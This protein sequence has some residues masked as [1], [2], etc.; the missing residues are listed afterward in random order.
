[1]GGVTYVSDVNGNLTNCG[2]DTLTYDQANRLT[3]AVVGSTIASYAYDGDGK[4]ASKTLNGS[5]KSFLYDIKAAVPKLLDD[6]E[7]RYVWR[8]SLAYATSMNG[9]DVVHVYHTD[10][11]ESARLLTN[12]SGVVTDIKRTDAFGVPVVQQ[13]TSTQPFGFAGEQRDPETSL[14]YLSARMYDP[15]LG[16]FV[17]RDALLG[18]RI[19]PNSLHRFTYGLNNPVRYVD[20]SGLDSDD[21]VSQDITNEVT[22]SCCDSE[23]QSDSTEAGS[24]TF[25]ASALAAS[26]ASLDDSKD[27]GSSE[28]PI[29]RDWSRAVE[30]VDGAALLAGAAVLATGGENIIVDGIAIGLGVAAGT[31]HIVHAITGWP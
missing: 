24:T 26:P 2:P 12:S 23:I 17:Q 1:V 28:T 30:V 10:G 20:P 16:R 18:S 27:G 7:R 15:T 3:Q 29:S 19:R 11:L 21:S 14:M 9:D 31:L 5:T 22:S 8:P 25:S 4:R 6:G 13:G